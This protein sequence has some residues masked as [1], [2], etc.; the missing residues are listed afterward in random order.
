M[1]YCWSF[2]GER[3]EGSQ[4]RMI[5]KFLKKEKAKKKHILIPERVKYQEEEKERREEKKKSSNF[6][7]FQVP[8]RTLFIG[9]PFLSA[10]FHALYTLWLPSQSLCVLPTEI[11]WPSWQF[12]PR[13]SNCRVVLFF[14]NIYI[15]FDQS[16]F[17]DLP[18]LVS[19]GLRISADVYNPSLPGDLCFAAAASLV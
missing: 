16:Q 12:Y 5:S 7:V 9:C 11:I 19:D 1:I 13:G 4:L 17:R 15:Q 2:L 8:S 10:P 18:C 6:C 14:L 3:E